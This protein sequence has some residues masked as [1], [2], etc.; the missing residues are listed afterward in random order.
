MEKIKINLPLLGEVE[1]KIN[2]KPIKRY[3]LRV[4]T[5]RNI[6]INAPLNSGIRNIENF[7]LSN[8]KWL[9]K[10]LGEKNN[11]K[12]IYYQG[13]YYDIEY[14]RANKFS[15][16]ITDNI[17]IFNVKNDK[18]AESA[19]KLFFKERKNELYKICLEKIKEYSDKYPMIFDAPSLKIKDM[20]SYGLYNKSKHLI[21]INSKLLQSE[22]E[23]IDMVVFH[24]LCHIAEQNHSSRFYSL[25]KIEF[26]N[27]KQI[28]KRLKIYNTR[29]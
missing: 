17:I 26:P 25:L 6:C 12:G 5:D 28:T 2:K 4:Y 13:K 21:T 19:R 3:Y 18:E 7:V 16:I 15:S 11:N 9:A 24:E 10:K 8:Q 23:C 22:K 14:R 20:V 1:I 29:F 27:Y